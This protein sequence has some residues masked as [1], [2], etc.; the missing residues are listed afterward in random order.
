MPGHWDDEPDATVE[1]EE[2][3]EEEVGQDTDPD[4]FEYPPPAALSELANV[5]NNTIALIVRSSIEHVFQHVEAERQRTE[6]PTTTTSQPSSPEPQNENETPGSPNPKEPDVAPEP[7]IAR[8]ATANSQSS[9]SHNSSDDFHAQTSNQRRHRFGIRRI[10]QHIVEKGESS[11]S[12]SSPFD[13]SNLP[14]HIHQISP[15]VSSA[16]PS[17][18]SSFTQLI[19]KHIKASAGVG[20]VSAAEA[21]TV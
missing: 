3:V 18:P 16:V 6:E 2:P 5:T 21:E 1:P 11:S 9:S 17:T 4:L 19:Y 15:Q 12:A 14:A 7:H 20:V 10:F 13:I 8:E